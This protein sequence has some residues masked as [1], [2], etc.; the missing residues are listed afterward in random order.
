M[1]Q[2]N[3]AISIMFIKLYNFINII[4]SAT[5]TWKEALN[6][7]ESI[8]FAKENFINTRKF[9]FHTKVL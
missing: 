3:V 4:E 9:Y 2:V 8:N 7:K 1:Q 6:Y 5:F